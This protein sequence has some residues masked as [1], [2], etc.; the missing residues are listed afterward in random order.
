MPRNAKHVADGDGRFTAI[1]PRLDPALLP[2]GMAS[3][4]RNMRFRNG[5]AESRKG[6]YK[7]PWANNITPEIDS[8]VRPFGEVH[9]VGVFRNPNNL[10]FVIIAA[11]NTVFYTR[12]NNNPIELSLPTGVSITGTVN[13]TQAFNKMI[14]WRGEDF[15]PL[16]MTSEDTGFLDLAEQWDS[17]A[18]YAVEDEVAF[19]PL[20]SV[21]SITHAAGV[22]TVTTATEH[23]YVTGADVTIAGSSDT[24]FNGRVNV[25]VTST[26]EFTYEVTSSTSPAGG[27]ITCTNNR[28]YYACTV[29]T[30]AGE[31]PATTSGSWSA[32]S[33]VMPNC[34]HG[35]FI[36]NRVTAP[37]RY[38]ASSAAYGN[39]RQ[40]IAVSDVLDLHTFFNQIFR[41]NF[42]SDSEILDLLVYDENRLL[43]FTDKD[44]AMVTGY[45]VTNEAAGTNTSFSSSVAI[46]PVIHNYGISGRGAA[47]VVGSDVYFYAS[48]RGIV[49]LSQTEQSKVRGVDM[50][51][52]EPVQPLID[53]QDPRHEDKI[54]LAYWDNKL[55]CAMGLDDASAGNNALL[56]YDF[57]NQGWSSHDTGDAINPAEFFVA[58]YNNA[59]RL[60]YVGTDGFINLIE[61]NDAGDDLADLTQADGLATTDFDSYLLT[62]GYHTNDIDHREFK[63]AAVNISTWNPNYT[64]NA[65]TDGANES[66]TLVS[67]R[68]KDRTAY[69]R[70]FDAL[71]YQEH[72]DNGDHADPYREDYS[73][74]LDVDADT[75]LTES[76]DTI[77]IE[78]VDSDGEGQAILI[79]GAVGGLTLGGGGVNFNRYQETLEPFALA[80][81]MGRYTQIELTNSTGRIRVNQATLTNSQGDRTIGVKS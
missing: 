50:P 26:T 1:A 66:Q 74:V 76:G 5:V 35:V 65:K 16:V 4:A 63:T 43:I 20:V 2:E 33:T 77:T 6:M 58:Q 25:T 13:F 11:D 10:E 3:E 68:S 80:P 37:T 8:K 79:E 23:G 29:I 69:Y 46:Q 41:I 51:L 48:R 57:L 22:A 52:S 39:H 49:S 71:P 15:A 36:A 56:V 28:D 38:D 62:R 40:F 21:S 24:E 54:R 12:Q 47:V 45:I 32:I 64:I 72:N 60:F 44:V 55:Y 81:R 73:V 30:S 42:G 61:E 75:F 78:E 7:C 67:S 70:P 31:S 9:G 17:T 27:T 34:T 18:A 19:G 14:M 53:R 59:Q